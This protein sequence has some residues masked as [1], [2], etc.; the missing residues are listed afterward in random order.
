MKILYVALRYDYGFPERGPSFEHFN[1]YECLARMGPQVDY[2]DFISI[3]NEVGKERMNELLI[4]RVKETSPD[5]MF[6]CLFRD[7]I[8][9]DTLQHITEGTETT[10]VNWFCDD[11]WRFDSFSSRYAPCFD[12]VTTT[13]KSALPKYD[14][15]RFKNVIKTQ[16]A[17]NPFTYRRLDI[18]LAYD[19]TFVG[20]PY[21]ERRAVVDR[22]RQ[23][24]LDIQAWGNGWE[25]GRVSQENMIRIFNQSRLNL[26][27]SNA[28][29]AQHQ[30]DTFGQRGA[31][32]SKLPGGGMVM[33][34]MC[35]RILPRITRRK[36]G[37]PVKTAEQIKGRNFEVP[38]CGGFML[39]GE[40]EDL[41]S[42][43]IPGKEIACFQTDEELIDLARY[44]LGSEEERAEVA[45]RGY[46]RTLHEHTYVHRFAEIFERVGHPL[47]Q[48][49]AEI[50]QALPSST[51]AV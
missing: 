6:T 18:S 13:A 30:R 25:N 43:Y 21:G 33:K 22:A 27:L 17:C 34:F 3:M 45:L 14:A 28:W 47:E 23:A 12:W 1:F 50:L 19:L 29:A 41:A 51:S 2:F 5:V 15:L 40:A 39:T 8:T 46:E 4:Q 42:Y 35:D 24:G 49:V 31:A 44:Y 26:N 9:P 48:P 7:E 16:W 32:L 37:E 20:Q 36:D 11:H 10:T 38:G